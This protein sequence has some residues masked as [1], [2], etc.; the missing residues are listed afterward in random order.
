[1]APAYWLGE[2]QGGFSMKK[3]LSISS[4]FVLLFAAAN[5]VEASDSEGVLVVTAS[6]AAT[7][8]LLVYNTADKVI[9]TVATGGQGG[10]SGN[11]GGIAVLGDVVAVVNFGSK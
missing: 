9:Q 5:I 10:V 1:M 11:A 3:I 7:N 8:Q 2:S 4:V 6:N